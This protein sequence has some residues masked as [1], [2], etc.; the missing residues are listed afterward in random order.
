MTWVY[1]VHM[2][3]VEEVKRR[4]EVTEV[5]GGYIQMKQSGRNLKANCPFHQE[6]TASF[7]VSPEK[8][9]WHCFGCG[10]G[11]DIYKF[12]MKMEGLDFREA[13]E[14][15]AK[16]AGVE[17]EAR[18]AM[19]QAAK[20][21]DRLIEAHK[22]AI[23]YYQASLVKNPRALEYLLKQ[24]EL[25]K[26]T[27]QLFQIGYAPDSWE[28]LTRFLIKRGFQ[29]QELV[30]AGLAGQKRGVYDMFRGRIM[31]PICDAQGTPIGF[32]GRVLGDGE[33]KYL[34]TPQTPL[35]DK[36]RA[37]FGLHLAKEAMRE[38]DAVILVEGNMD[39][40]SSQQA[41]VKNV[42]AASG[43]ALSQ[44]QLKALSKFTRRIRIA[45]DQ[46]SA[47]LKASARAIELAGQLGLRLEVIEVDAK[48]PDELIKRDPNLWRA[49]AEQAKDIFSYW[50][51]RLERELDI[52]SPLGKRQYADKMAGLIQTVAD[53]IERE[54]YMQQLANKVGM[55]L[56]VVK[57]K[58]EEVEVPL[59]DAPRVAAI[60]AERLLSPGE[61]VQASALAVAVV[62]PDCRLYLQ[63]LSEDDL[64][65]E[66]TETDRIIWRALLDYPDAPSSKLAK[67]LP[68]V[69]DRVKILALRG[70]EEFAS[71][72]PADR[73]HEAFRLSRRLQSLSGKSAK[74]KLTEQLRA[75]EKSGDFK[76]V[77]SLLKQYQGLIKNQD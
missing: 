68:D 67:L 8:G 2:D 21:R 58:I 62:Y 30:Q 28:G 25:R 14:M 1:N 66:P 10:E 34:N 75:A 9:I 43:T 55:S 57:Q 77:H 4:L 59:D 44:D 76:L 7:M 16:R 15:L 60:P 35:Y 48:D 73:S 26:E 19:K 11:G 52:E 5:V 45:F 53:P 6:K 29:P 64:V 22:L 49:A 20:T 74:N 61:R 46:D 17:L 39:V 3:Q 51:G 71:L 24:R 33:P 72:S 56:D 47:G 63:D 40:V 50:F 70:E 23:K 37:V 12:V 41:G 13:L 54:A 18:P 38:A 42:V 36:S 65:Y 31:L 69:S 27:L 32:T